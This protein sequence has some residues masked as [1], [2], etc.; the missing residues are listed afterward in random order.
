M[1]ASLSVILENVVSVP[2]KELTSEC[3]KSHLQKFRHDKEKS[4]VVFMK[5]YD[6]WIKK[7]TLLALR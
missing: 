2:N 4:V 5:E 6:D 1:Q 7:Q 3:I